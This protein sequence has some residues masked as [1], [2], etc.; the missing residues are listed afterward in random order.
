MKDNELKGNLLRFVMYTFTESCNEGIRLMID[1]AIKTG[2]G[3]A[4]GFCKVRRKMSS[5][6]FVKYK[7]NLTLEEMVDDE[8]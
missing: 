4:V 2:E 6:E 5:N 8:L 3:S 1:D 7:L